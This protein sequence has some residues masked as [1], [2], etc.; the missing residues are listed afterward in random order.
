MSNELERRAA[1]LAELARELD[2]LGTTLAEAG[3]PPVREDE[4][5]AWRAADRYRLRRPRRPGTGAG[6]VVE[7]D[8][9]PYR[10][11][12][13]TASPLPGDDRRCALLEPARA[14]VAGA[15]PSQ[16]SSSASPKKSADDA[17]AASAGT[18]GSVVVRAF[19]PSRASRTSAGIAPSSVP[20]KSAT[21]TA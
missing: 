9:G 21:A 2:E 3:P 8:D 16:A 7:L 14:R 17:P 20:A 13:V 12:R 18:Y 1:E 19:D 11:V 6:S 15:Q 4:H 5:V 10:C